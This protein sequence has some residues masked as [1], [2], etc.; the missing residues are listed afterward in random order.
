MQPR[1]AIMMGN[2]SMFYDV[3]KYWSKICLKREFQGPEKTL[4]GTLWLRQTHRFFY[5]T[6]WSSYKQRMW[7]KCI[8]LLSAL[9]S[10]CWKIP[11]QFHH[12]VNTEMSLPSI[13]HLENIVLIDSVNLANLQIHYLILDCQPSTPISIQNQTAIKRQLGVRSSRLFERGA[14][15][16]LS[17]SRLMIHFQSFT[18]THIFFKVK[19]FSS[20]L[21]RSTHTV[22]R[23]FLFK[24]TEYIFFPKT[25]M[26]KIQNSSTAVSTDVICTC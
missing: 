15:P 5:D 24:R 11:S 2:Y 1:W 18:F 19:L 13:G 4:W 8:F 10:N 25:C 17:I 6:F 16:V 21:Q 26:C 9:Q 23:S 12:V 22:I 3:G 14:H 20:S 7:R